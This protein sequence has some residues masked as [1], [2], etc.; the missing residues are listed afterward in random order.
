MTIFQDQRSYR[1]RIIQD[2]YMKRITPEL[3]LVLLQQH[4]EDQLAAPSGLWWI[5]S[6]VAIVFFGWVLWVH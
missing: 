1:R 2:I 3:G 6:I 4:E 5:L